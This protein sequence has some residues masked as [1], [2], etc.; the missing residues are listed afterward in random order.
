MIA[1]EYSFMGEKWE[2]EGKK[3]TDWQ[4]CTFM[5]AFNDSEV[6]GSKIFTTVIHIHTTNDSA[7]CVSK[8][9][10]RPQQNPVITFSILLRKPLTKAATAINPQWIKSDMFRSRKFSYVHIIHEKQM[11]CTKNGWPTIADKS[12]KVSN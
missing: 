8:V 11:K 7:E 3:K 12:H 4:F 2:T 1:T 6:L 5:F 9:T 10:M